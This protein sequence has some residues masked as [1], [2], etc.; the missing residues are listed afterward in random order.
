LAKSGIN[1]LYHI[2]ILSRALDILETIQ[3][4]KQSFSLESLH[5][6]TKFSKTTV[7]RILKTLEHRG[8]LAHQENGMYRLL[9]RPA[10]ICFGFGGQSEE[11]PFS[12]AVTDSLK[13]A[14]Q[15]SGVELLVLDN[16]YDGR[17]AVQNAKQFVE[18]RVDLVIEFQIEQE[19]AP[20]VADKIAKV[21]IPLIAVEIPHPHATYFGVDNY[22]VGFVAGEFLG[23]YAKKVWRGNVT[24]V[25]GLDI[26]EAGPL[27]QSRITGAFEG[28]RG[29]LPDL[30]AESFVRMDARGLSEKS[31]KVTSEF[32]QR[33]PTDRGI[34]IAAADDT[35]ALGALKA[36]KQLKR[37]K[38]VAIV[39]QDC[40]PEALD[41]IRT[42]GSP[43]IASVSREVHTYGPRLIQLGL[44]LVRG[45]QIAPYH[46]VDHRLVT[47]EVLAAQAAASPVSA[48]GSAR[49]PQKSGKNL[50][51]R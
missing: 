6:R 46:Y 7:Y 16:R 45:Q 20:I 26:D 31:C 24:W 51:V 13:A 30:P 49:H 38:Y 34:L 8:Y 50:A 18:K 29:I 1:R 41:E 3:A 42:I 37:E 43:L 32:L 35:S 2:P 10:K 23:Q 39:G 40:I 5:Q 33:H 19:V 48:P 9:S 28:V 11:L 21:G 25:L 36:V 22:R 27:V 14:A 15:A 44:A 12:Q 4:E 17:T 47:A